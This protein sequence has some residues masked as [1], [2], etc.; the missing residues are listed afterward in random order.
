MALRVM[1]IG[2]DHS[3]AKEG[4]AHEAITPGHCVGLRAADS[5]VIK[6]TSASVIAKCLAVAV[7]QDYL[8]PV[9]GGFGYDKDDA[10]A[11]GDQVLYYSP[12]RGA[13]FHGLVGAA[14]PAIV[15]ND[16]LAVSTTV[17]GCLEKTATVANAVAIAREAVDNS[18]GATQ[19]RIRV[20]AL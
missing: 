9:A 14:A 18:G 11:A 1:I 2:G 19:V 17:A 16:L 15:V 5:K 6:A 13:E 20:E 10:Y 8:G 3:L 12:C 7:E 4:V